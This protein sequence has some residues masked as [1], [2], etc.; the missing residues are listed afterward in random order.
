LKKKIKNVPV[1]LVNFDTEFK[2]IAKNYVKILQDE[3][4]K[5]SDFLIRQKPYLISDTVFRDLICDV[6]EIYYKNK[7]L[8]FFLGKGSYASVYLKKV[9]SS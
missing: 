5:T 4:I 7:V 3:G 2:G 6:K 8:K 1:P 9:I